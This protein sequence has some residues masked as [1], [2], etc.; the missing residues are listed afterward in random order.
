VTVSAGET[1]LVIWGNGAAA[2]KA[3]LR[4]NVVLHAAGPCSHSVMALLKHLAAVGFE[5]ASRPVGAA[6]DVSQSAAPGGGGQAGVASGF[7]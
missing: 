5:G 4:Q 6:F 3:H 7:C 2:P 1:P